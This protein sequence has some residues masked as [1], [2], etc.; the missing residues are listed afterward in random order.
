MFIGLDILFDDFM[1]QINYILNLSKKYNQYDWYYKPHTHELKGDI[2][3]H[4]QMLHKYPNV[5]LLKP[6]VSH[7]QIIKTK[8]YCIITNH[9]TVGHEYIMFKIPAI[10]NGD[11]KHIN[12]NFGFTH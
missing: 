4:K 7:N 1:D 8:P 6:T 5:K 2:E 11:N 3:I 10:F 9:G 12:Y